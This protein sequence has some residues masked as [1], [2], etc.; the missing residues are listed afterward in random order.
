MCVRL[1]LQISGTLTIKRTSLLQLFPGIT[2]HLLP[3]HT[4]GLCGM[5]VN[6]IDSGTFVFLSDH[7]HVKENYDGTPQGWLGERCRAV[8]RS[9]AV[10]LTFTLTVARDHQAWFSSNER[11]KRLEKATGGMIVPGHDENVVTPLFGKIFT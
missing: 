9:S 3:G 5:Q 1:L 6:L 4:A 11:V 2:I 10:K 7:A 8:Q